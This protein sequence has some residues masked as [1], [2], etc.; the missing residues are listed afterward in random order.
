[1]QSEA[2]VSAR[3]EDVIESIVDWLVV[4]AG[5]GREELETHLYILR[6]VDVAAHLLCGAK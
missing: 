4:L 3:G 2:I 1:M 5:H 6:G